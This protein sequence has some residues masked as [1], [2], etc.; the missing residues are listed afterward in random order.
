MQREN[1]RKYTVLIFV[2]IISAVYVLGFVDRGWIPHDE[3]S[4][5][6]SAQRVLDGEL[7]HRDFD[8]IYTGGLSFLYAAAFKSVGLNLFSIRIVLLIFFL[9]FVPSLYAIALRFASPL[10]AGAIALLGVAW[11]VPNYF[12]GVPSWYNLFFATFGTLALIRHVETQKPKWLF[13]AGLCGG[14]S[15]ITKVSGIYYVIAALLFLTYRELFI[16]SDRAQNR[17]MH[18]W[19]FFSLK[20]LVYACFLGF[21]IF[22]LRFR[23]GAMEA[24][25]FLLPVVSICVVLLEAEW[26]VG[27]GRFRSRL[28]TLFR[29]LFPFGWGVVLPVIIL[30]IPYLFTNSVGDFIQG[31][32]V[33]PQKRLLSATMRFPPFRTV[34]ASIPYATLLLFPFVRRHRLRFDRRFQMALMIP[35]ALALSSSENFSVYQS[36][37]QSARSLSVVAVL[38]GCVTLIQSLRFSLGSVAQRQILLLLIVTTALVSLV[39]FPFA[40]PIYF[41]YAAPLVAVT[42]LAIVTIQP[43]APQ[44]LHFG[45]LCFYLLFAVFWMNTGYVPNLGIV[46][47]A[48]RPESVLDL[49]RGGIRVTES[50]KALYTQLVELIRKKHGGSPYIYA[51]PDCPEVYFLSGMRNP[52]RTIFDFLNDS[53]S[54]PAWLSGV[55][56]TNNVNVVAINRWPH[57][58][59]EVSP[60]LM[61]VLEDR[62]PRSLDL[63]QFTVRWRE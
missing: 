28:E 46:Y 30:L 9:G 32:F 42:L 4:L 26:Q 62:F 18:S 3:G 47:T 24:L 55:L 45:I 25:H 33:A 51:T 39:Q 52:T 11:S 60:N 21:L 37:W 10:L 53:Q 27:Q 36:V 8:E 49:G 12:A 43:S 16:A 63:G 20:G 59:G 31:V 5:A 61:A 34:A 54:E 58:S 17:P 29:L 19:A 35:L 7:P 41:V 15:S 13:L 57:F 40:G 56:E 38:G 22:L 6:Q 44:L 2:W 48:Y 1:S 23:L 50:D 14:F